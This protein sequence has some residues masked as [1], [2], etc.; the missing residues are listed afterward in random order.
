VGRKKEILRSG[1]SLREKRQEISPE[2]LG[3]KG[4]K[5][6]RRKLKSQLEK[7]AEKATDKKEKMPYSSKLKGGNMSILG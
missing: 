2:K 6:G 5:K 3:R 1:K 7:K 4:G